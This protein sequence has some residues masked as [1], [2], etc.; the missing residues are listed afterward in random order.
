M[1]QDRFKRIEQKYLFPVGYSDVVRTWLEHAC[2]PDP[3]Y[4]SSTVSSIY[5]DTPQLFHFNES[6]NGE[7]LRTKIR[8]RWYDQPADRCPSGASHDEVLC[9]LE[10]KNKEG[11]LSGKQRTPVMLPPEVLHDDPFSSEQILDLPA[12][13]FEL[14]FH[15]SGLMVPI[16]MIQYRRQRYLDIAADSGIAVDTEIL[17]TRAGDIILQGAAP[18][19]LDVGVLEIKGMNRG[20]NE[21]LDPI[22]AYLTKSSFSKYRIALE[23]LMQ[24]LERRV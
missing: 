14:G 2:V 21:V 16:L 6:R 7:F 12:R 10:V 24:P 4:P 17:C 19:Q 3:L 20:I 23:S 11:A 15:L 18:V 5:F 13:A 9:Y 8:L 1:E 22:G